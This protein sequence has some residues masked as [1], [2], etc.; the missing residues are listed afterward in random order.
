MLE[1]FECAYGG[2]GYVQLI[3]AIGAVTVY[4]S[5]GGVYEDAVEMAERRTITTYIVI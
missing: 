2:H 1:K 3:S 4:L 5:F